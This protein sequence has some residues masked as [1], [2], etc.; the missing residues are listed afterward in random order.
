[1]SGNGDGK[2]EDTKSTK[3]HEEIF[4]M[5]SSGRKNPFVNRVPLKGTGRE[6]FLAR[7]RKALDHP[8]GKSPLP[9]GVP[10]LEQL[11][12]QVASDDAG[13]V[14]RFV[15]KMTE[16]KG[17]V[18]RVGAD[19][20]AVLAAV[21]A[22]LAAHAVKRT[23]M[24]L[25]GLGADFGVAGHLRGRGVEMVEWGMPACFVESF[26]C[27]VSITDS[28]AGLAGT[29]AGL[30][31]WVVG[32]WRSSTLVVPVHITLLP[33]SR[34]LGDLIDGLDVV[35]KLGEGKMPSNVVVIN[36]PSKTGDIEMKLV[37]GVHGPKYMYVIVIDGM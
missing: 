8:E 4:D 3:D 30:G 27:D 14:D 29:G 7:V 24:N 31:W 25:Q 12:R 18:K 5:Q 10:E 17:V 33:A 26:S 23:L 15:K 13:R 16:N 1:M 21:D 32:F 36:G 35:L 2:H 37:T 22:C 20:E 6:E 34:I 19:R 9:T 11:I 28:R